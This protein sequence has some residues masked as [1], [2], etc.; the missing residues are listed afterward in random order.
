MPAPIEGFADGM[1]TTGMANAAIAFLGTGLM[2]RPIA[3]RLLAAGHD[4]RL[5]NRSPD[6]LGPL[7]AVGG[8][9]CAS[10]AERRPE[11]RSSACAFVIHGAPETVGFAVDLQEHLIEVPSPMPEAA[12]RTRPLPADVAREH[13]TEPVPPEANRRG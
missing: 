12:H 10:P 5:W 13:R 11:P 4:L 6:K 2:G 9:R 7:L 3:A 8:R 1:A